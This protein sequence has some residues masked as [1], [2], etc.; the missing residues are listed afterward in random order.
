MAAF[1]NKTRKEVKNQNNS[2]QFMMGNVTVNTHNPMR[3]ESLGFS[4]SCRFLKPFPPQPATSL[5]WIY[6]L[7]RSEED[8]SESVFSQIYRTYFHFRGIPS[9]LRKEKCDQCQGMIMKEVK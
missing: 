4:K 6:S 7:T 8:M 5:R 1:A 3:T 9:N 2:S